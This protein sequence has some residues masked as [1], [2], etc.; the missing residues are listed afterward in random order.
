MFNHLEKSTVS[1][2]HRTLTLDPK[3]TRPLWNTNIT[4]FLSEG[5]TSLL[6]THTFSYKATTV[7]AQT[8]FLS[9]ND[10]EFLGSANRNSTLEQSP[11][12]QTHS[13]GQAER[14]W[15]PLSLLQISGY[16][17]SLWRNK[18]R[19]GTGAFWGWDT[20]R[21]LGEVTLLTRPLTLDPRLWA[22]EVQ[23]QDMEGHTE[24]GKNI[25][26]VLALMSDK[27]IASNPGSSIYVAEVLWG[28]IS[29]LWASVSPSIK[30]DVIFKKIA[31]WFFLPGYYI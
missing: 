28:F 19:K 8:T 1:N 27:C 2:L 12:S 30:R 29:S 5:K 23:K 20:F 13:W 15:R 25:Y 6:L 26:Q 18:N 31:E 9:G 22:S 10:P 14:P 21:D 24:F 16:H 11:R 7:F 17:P 4:P 3:E